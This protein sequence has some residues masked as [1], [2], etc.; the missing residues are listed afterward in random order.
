MGW[1]ARKKQTVSI[2][3]TEAKLLALIHA[4]KEVISFIHLFDKLDFGYDHNIT[5]SYDNLQ[6]I[7]IPK[8]GLP[9]IAT[10]LIINSL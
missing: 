7:R 8:S 9:R 10:K 1:T 3:T 4:K 2:S 5:L 6:T